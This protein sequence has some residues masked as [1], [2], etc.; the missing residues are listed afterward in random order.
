[1]H[2]GRVLDRDQRVQLDPADAKLRDRG[3]A[4]GEEARPVV[5]IGPRPRDHPGSVAGA[6]VPLVVLDHHVDRIGRDQ[7]LLNEQRLERGRPQARVVDVVA[8]AHALSR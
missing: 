6:E 7:A 4:V 8:V 3:G 2:L 5:G 1:V